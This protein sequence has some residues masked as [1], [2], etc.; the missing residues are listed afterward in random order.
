MI[1]NSNECAFPKKK[2]G[3]IELRPQNW[4]YEG[5]TGTTKKKANDSFRSSASIIAFTP[6]ARA[7][8]TEKSIWRSCFWIAANADQKAWFP[9]ATMPAVVLFLLSSDRGVNNIKVL[10]WSQIC[11]SI[12]LRFNHHTP[13]RKAEVQFYTTLASQSLARWSSESN[14][15]N[16]TVFLQSPYEASIARGKGQP[17]MM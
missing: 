10:C 16:C 17:A 13:K 11:L 8:H 1:Y 12:A 3:H 9:G 7:D 5:T 15:L 4:E 6:E 2:K 14:S